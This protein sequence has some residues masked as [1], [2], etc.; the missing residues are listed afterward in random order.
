MERFRARR[1]KS[2]TIYYYFD[3]GQ[4]PRKE[5][6][7]GA[8]YVL[9]VRKWAELIGSETKAVLVSNFEELAREYERLELP[10]KAKST[11]ATNRSD[12]KLLRQFFN[13]PTPAPL[14]QIKPPHIRTLLRWK[15]SQPTTAN[16][17]K[18][19]FSHMFNMA[20]EWGYTEAT[21]PVKGVKGFALGKREVYVSDAVFIAVYRC[22]SQPL[23][24]AMDLAYLTGQRPGDVLQFTERQIADGVFTIARQAKTGTPLRIRI[25]GEFGSLIERIV[26]RKADYKVWSAALA[27]NLRGLPL[28]KQ[29]LRDHFERARATAAATATPQMA[30]EILKFWF[31]DLRAKA[32]DDVS[33]NRGDQA[34]ANLLGHANVATTQRHYLRR[35]KQVG[36][37][38]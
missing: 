25:E 33:D 17:L 26:K 30:P 9:A 38:K 15:A 18:R 4:R 20:R 34:A 3:T 11:Q 35:G 22:A 19:L 12:L 32:A 37:T 14:D 21:N 31:Y 16:R 7:L 27:V 6:P 23:K 36:P 8:D 24:D 2:G 29:V 5:I 1:Q 28:T 10:K 13:N